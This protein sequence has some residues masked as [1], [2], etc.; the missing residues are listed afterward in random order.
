MSSP[1]RGKNSRLTTTESS[2]IRSETNGRTYSDDLRRESYQH[3]F[4]KD[5]EARPDYSALAVRSWRNESYLPMAKKP[6]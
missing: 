6:T 3:Y 4:F 5:Q 1:L 2:R